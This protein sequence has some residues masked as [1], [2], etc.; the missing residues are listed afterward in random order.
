MKN[1]IFRTAFA[2][3]Y[4]YALGRVYFTVFNPPKPK[5]INRDFEY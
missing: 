4:I 2:G 3:L 5:N 1:N